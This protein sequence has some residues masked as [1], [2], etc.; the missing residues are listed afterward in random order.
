MGRKHSEETKRKI[1]ASKKGKHSYIIHPMLGKKH[2]KETKQKWSKSRKGNQVGIENPFF[3]RKHSEESKQKIREKKIGK[4]ISK[5]SIKKQIE[6]KIRNGT[7]SHSEE[8]K[9]KIGYA[10]KGKLVPEHQKKILS[11]L[12]KGRKLSKEIRNK[13]SKSRS[14]EKHFNWQGGKSFEPYTTDWTASLK[15]AIRERDRYTCQL[16]SEQQKESA[17]SVHHIDYDKTNCNPNNL[18]TLCKGCHTKTNYNRERWKKYF[19]QK[20]NINED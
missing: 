9:R 3:G 5:E 20:V 14:L 12:Y 2:S 7:N 19:K 1:S 10:N 8:T 17:F 16:C 13:M 6:T 11:K 4:T 18:I 15:R